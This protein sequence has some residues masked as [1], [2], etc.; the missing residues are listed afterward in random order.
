MSLI[1]CSEC[2][3]KVSDSANSCPKCGHK[4]K[5][6]MLIDFNIDFLTS[7]RKIYIF[8]I[9]ALLSLAVFNPDKKDFIKFAKAEFLKSNDDYVRSNP[10]GQ[11]LLS[12]LINSFLEEY[13]ERSSY[14]FFSIYEVDL[15]LVNALRNKGLP[16][17]FL[18]IGS[19]FLVIDSSESMFD[20]SK[21]DTGPYSNAPNKKLL[22]SNEENKIRR[23]LEGIK[24]YT[25]YTVVR[26]L[27]ISS[28]WSP[29]TQ[30]GDQCFERCMNHRE[31]G[32]I[33]AEDCSGTG[34][35]HCLF[36]YKNK[37]GRILKIIT[38]DEDP[39]F[40]GYQLES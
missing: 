34:L 6:K 35:G 40:F 32:W 38:R 21:S 7:M 39:G 11:A 3:H 2:N 15:S 22:S 17:K 37:H 26:K 18:G 4:I 33:E 29:V 36:V 27:L 28:D 30:T 5:Q 23:G 14:V 12:G 24:E 13:A 20:F 31:K 8:I 16:E 19:Y 9:I 25:P 1:N 10:F